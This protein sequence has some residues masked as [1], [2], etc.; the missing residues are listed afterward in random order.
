MEEKICPKCGKLVHHGWRPPNLLPLSMRGE[1]PVAGVRGTTGA[2]GVTGT[3]GLTGPKG[4]TGAIGPT[5]PS[6]A[7]GATGSTGVTG[8]TGPTGVVGPMGR[9]GPTGPPGPV[10]NTGP[11]GPAGPAG[12]IGA[13]G[14]AAFGESGLRLE[15]D[16]DLPLTWQTG[17]RIRQVSRAVLALSPGDYQISFYLC[18]RLNGPGYIQLTPVYNGEAQVLYADRAVSSGE[19]IC[20]ARTFI[21]SVPKGGKLF[22]VFH[23][24]GVLENGVS[25]VSVVKL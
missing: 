14:Y 12:V 1:K 15:N 10:G 17:E 19:R 23:S 8:P 4:P 21:G 24:S 20:V 3:T 7:R 5:G 6:G 22:F 25:S 18:G 13:A 16:S 9:I 2:T 11:T